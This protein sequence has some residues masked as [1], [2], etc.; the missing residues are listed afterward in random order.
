VVGRGVRQAAG[1]EPAVPARSWGR[2]P[3]VLLFLGIAA[4][5]L[6][7]ALL[8][9]A[10]ETGDPAW[11]AIQVLGIL[12][13]FWVRARRPELPTSAWFAVL[14]G[15]SPVSST[16]EVFAIAADR[17]G[18]HLVVAGAMAT[19]WY[20]DALTGIA[21]VYLV[22]FF[23]DGRADRAW[24]RWAVRLVWPG[25]VLPTLRVFGEATV[26]VPGY[27]DVAETA[28][29]L[30][31]LPFTVSPAVG[32]WLDSA[33]ALFMLAALVVLAVRYRSLSGPARRGVRWLLVP[34][35]L[36]PFGIITMLLLG[37]A[38]V[39]VW[40]T[41]MLVMLTLFVSLALGIVQPRSLDVDRVLRRTLVYGVLWLAIAAMYVGLAAAVGVTAQHYLSVPWAIVLALVAGL[42]FQPARARLE[43][44]ADRWVFGTRPDPSR[45]LGRLGET[46][47]E[48][49]DLGTLLPRMGAALE[50]GLDVDWARVRL[51]TAREDPGGEEP[52]VV[53]PVVLDGEQVGVVE[54]GPKRH[55]AWTEQDDAVVATFARQAA[56]AV[57]NVRL[58]QDLAARAAEVAASRTRLVRAQ[59]SE[60]RRIE[61]NIHDGV[62]Q[63]LVALIALAGQLGSSDPQ[64]AG[65]DL[66]LLRDGLARV[67]DEVRDLARGI[68]PS[69][70]SDSGL[71]TAV[72]SLTARHPVPVE[73]RADQA[74]RSVR[75]AEDAEAACYFTVSEALANSLKHADASLVQ[76]ELARTDGRLVVTVA[77][78]G[79][80]FDTTT[81]NGSGGLSGM[82]DRLA[83]LGGTVDVRSAPREGTTVRAEIALNGSRA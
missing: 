11:T 51:A 62:Q 20:V 30:H 18:S 2:F 66:A 75:F 44:L 6:Q 54:C 69:L 64:R 12:L 55:G 37:D 72:E 26:P 52:A 68:H 77:D 46:L 19:S 21:A 29:P 13:A 40:L 65:E 83:A 5:A 3:E 49:F 78:D 34:L 7:V 22:A 58:A 31:W 16:V 59:E 17:Q 33:T 43:R 14:T 53:H 79:S 48:T 47:A 1:A 23:P 15:L 39:V 10:G 4:V 28:N 36:M 73:L 50:E 63:D 61:R 32:A 25:L 56:L 42:A 38:E 74:L 76:V 27:V 9:S 80:G 57:H 45:V 71:L 70:L 82:G 24:Q 35:S 67:L 41:W 8:V 81:L 60:R